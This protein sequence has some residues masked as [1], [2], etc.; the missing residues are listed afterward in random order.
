MVT[1]DIAALVKIAL[2]FAAKTIHREQVVSSWISF[3]RF[4][5]TLKVNEGNLSFR[6]KIMFLLLKPGSGGTR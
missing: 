5:L 2:S 1:G 3:L 6:V 4:L